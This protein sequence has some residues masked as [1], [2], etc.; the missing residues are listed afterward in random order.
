MA[1]GGTGGHMVPGLHLLAHLVDRVEQPAGLGRSSLAPGT[2]ADRLEHILWLRG[3]R[4]VEELVLA[5]F[6]R[7][8][9]GVPAEI[10]SLGLDRP[11]GGARPL[12]G[13]ALRLPAAA[14]AAARALR[15]Q[16]STVLLGLG[17]YVSAPAV[18]GARL[19]RVPVVL[20]EVNALAGRATR[21]LAPLARHVVHAWPATLPG[22]GPEKTGE[23]GRRHLRLGPPL[24]PEYLGASD[25][26]AARERLGFSA[27]RPLL[28]VLGGSQGAGALNAFL[29]RE[30][31]ALIKG[32]L[33]ILH[34]TGPGRLSEA[35]GGLPGEYYRA[36]E[37]LDPVAE[38]LAGST[39]T[40]CRGG[41]GTLAEVAGS[42]LPAWVVPYEHGDRHQ[43]RNAA[44]L[45]AGA[46][47][48]TEATL[49]AT[50]GGATRE[51]LGAAADGE[52]RGRMRA[53][54]ARAMPR[55]GAAAL[56]RLLAELS[57]TNTIPGGR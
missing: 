9:A 55:D 34:Q 33:S 45:G 40:L 7:R 8:C 37:Y 3:G 17:G 57:Q 28:L 6:P 31:D 47:V 41:A 24:A 44:Q 5:D 50:D 52:L 35:A 23:R 13:Q 26:G 29:A 56:G 43:A 15:Q 11:G 38:A 16:G 32:G 30:G 18:L 14:R 46:R 49:A 2:V 27:G 42:C 22:G 53:A 25:D 21:T 19:A 10:I 20:L 4:P 54:L 36:V 51:L 39:L 1:G 12:P 48:L